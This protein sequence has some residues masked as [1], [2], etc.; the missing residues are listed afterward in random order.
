MSN[1]RGT[2]SVELSPRAPRP[3]DMDE[4][5]RYPEGVIEFE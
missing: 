2:G 5:V 1:Y 4:Q 3:G